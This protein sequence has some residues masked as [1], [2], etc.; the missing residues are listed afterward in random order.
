MGNNHSTLARRSVVGGALG[1]AVTLWAGPAAAGAGAG[2]QPSWGSYPFTLGVASGAP[3]PDGV[4]LWTRLAPAPLQA[5]GG[6]PPHTVTVKWQVAEDEHF[7]RIVRQGRALARPDDA[8][9]V[10][11]DVHGLRPDRWYHYRFGSGTAISRTGR[12][13]TLPAPGARVSALR[14]A[15]A[16]C[17][18]YEHGYYSAYRHMAAQNPDVVVHL[19]DYIYE[20]T[21]TGPRL[22]AM[23]TALRTTATDLTAYRLRHSLYRLDPDLQEAHAAAPWLL[24]LDN[25]DAVEDGTTTASML[26]RRVAAYRAYYEHLPLS[27]QSRP[28]GPSMRI[29]DKIDYGR[30]LRLHLLDTRQHR[31]TEQICGGSSI[32]GEACPAISAQQRTMLGAQQERWLRHSMGSSR[33][34]WNALTQTVLFAPYKFRSGDD[35]SSIYYASWDGYTAARRRLLDDI[36]TQRPSNPVMLSGDWHT[37]WV[38]SVPAQMQDL[39]GP[40]VMTEFLTTGI[41]SNPAYTSALAKPSLAGNPQVHYYDE[42]C[43]YTLCTVTPGTWETTFVT[44]D[45][46]ARTAPVMATASWT[47]E[48]GHPQAHRA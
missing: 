36:A 5:D 39:D 23:P 46:T 32:V 16:S 33:T 2:A 11:V 7:T 31:D 10:H 13:R 21:L 35:T 30:L 6:M 25:H 29:H 18:R 24:I 41:S 34:T 37:A 26:A 48:S 44:A 14:L 8:H 47:V 28:N 17:Q 22:E 4:V 20:N 45:T 3:R 43:G 12:T 42:H 1:A 27:P 38:N 40:P 9:S 19:G 15:L